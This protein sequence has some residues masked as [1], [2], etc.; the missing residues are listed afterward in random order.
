MYCSNGTVLNTERQT[1]LGSQEMSRQEGQKIK[2]CVSTLHNYLMWGWLH[3][4]SAKWLGQNLP[5]SINEVLNCIWSALKHM[6][7]NHTKPRHNTSTYDK[8]SWEDSKNTCEVHCE[9]MAINRQ[10]TFKNFHK[11]FQWDLDSTETKFTKNYLILLALL[12]TLQ[13]WLFTRDSQREEFHSAETRTNRCDIQIKLFNK[14]HS[15][16]SR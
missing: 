2:K 5:W 16:Q 6:H 8:G 10:F 3:T 14:I 11:S 9:D 1:T 4:L 15:E 13:T 12:S 7:I